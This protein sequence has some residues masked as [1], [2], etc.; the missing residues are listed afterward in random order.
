MSR[1]RPSCV[2]TLRKARRSGSCALRKFYPGSWLPSGKDQIA[3]T[4]AKR[5]RLLSSN[6]GRKDYIETLNRWGQGTAS[7]WT[8][9]KILKTIP[10]VARL[11]PRYAADPDFRVQISS[12]RHNDQQVCFIEEIMSHEK[13]VLRKAGL[14]RRD[15]RTTVLSAI[16]STHSGPGTTR[17]W[18]SRGSRCERSPA[19]TARRRD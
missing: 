17:R 5:F 1:S 13:N 2:S 16:R 18:R 3:A 6:N 12:L 10:A 11:I 9:P 4:A 7:L 8:F 19:T 15:R 14:R